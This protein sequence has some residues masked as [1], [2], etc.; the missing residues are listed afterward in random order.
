MSAT[1]KNL[2]DAY[3]VL[4]WLTKIDVQKRRL[5]FLDTQNLDFGECEPDVFEVV[6]RAHHAPKAR[7]G[8]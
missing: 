4:R 7:K 2:R 6:R 1:A 3:A 8:P 5:Y